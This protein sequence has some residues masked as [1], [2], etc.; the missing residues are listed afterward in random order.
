[1][2][3]LLYAPIT[4]QAALRPDAPAIVSDGE[5]LTYGELEESSNRLARLL[6][7]AGCS[8]GDRVCVLMPKG[9]AVVTAI[10]GVLK[11]DAIWVPIDPASS[12]AGVRRILASCESKWILASDTHV[13]VL[14]EL[15]E[16]AEFAATHMVGWLSRTKIDGRGFRAAF[17]WTDLDIYSSA[18]MHCASGPDDAA[19]ILFTSGSTGVSKGVV[20][21]HRN[22]LSFLRWAKPHFGTSADD[23]VSWHSP[24]HFNLTTFD[25]FGTLGAGAALYPVP[26]DLGVLPHRLAEFIRDTELT[27]WFSLPSVL[28]YMANFEALRYGDFPSVRRILWCG[29]GLPTPTLIYW[30]QRVSHSTFTALY[31]PTEAAIASSYFTVPACPEDKD[32]AIPIGRAYPGAELL[33]LDDMLRPLPAGEIGDLYI[34]GVG[35]SPGYWRDGKKTRDAFLPNPLNGSPGDRIYRTG[36]LARIG[37]DGFVYYVGRADVQTKSRVYRVDVGE[38]GIAC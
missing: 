24:L 17:T 10:L 27:Q 5:Q 9:A 34:G 20:V 23:R 22:V 33:V 11:A 12:A 25:I 7:A 19:H 36:D 35:V 13:E 3:D 16:D 15:F 4:A 37:L 30:M 6:R 26:P 32:L 21:T 31:G 18:P 28:S 8:R 29:K 2:R 38:A 14:D 1:M